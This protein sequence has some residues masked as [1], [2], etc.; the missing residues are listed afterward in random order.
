MIR[1][2]GFHPLN[3]TLVDNLNKANNLMTHLCHNDFAGALREKTVDTVG[4]RLLL[5]RI[6]GSTQE[7]DLRKPPNCDGYGRIHHFR[8][9]LDPRWTEIA[10]PMDPA[11]KALGIPRQEL[12]NAEVFQYAACNLSCWYCFVPQELTR[13]EEQHGRWF[14]AREL[15]RLYQ[16]QPEPPQIIDLS[17]GNPELVPEWVP[18]MMKALKDAH[19]ERKVYLWS[20]DSL[21]NTVAGKWLS[22]SDSELM[23]SYHAYGRV[24]CF[25]GFS[26]ESFHFNT[27]MAAEQFDQQFRAMAS[28]LSVGIDVY[29]YVTLTT[30]SVDHLRADIRSFVERLQALRLNLPLRTIPLEIVSFSPT[31]ARITDVRLKAITCYQYDAV[32][33]WREE[34]KSR[35]SS[36]QL[37]TN[38]ADVPL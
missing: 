27:G 20:D 33:C 28:L 13:G 1:V 34:L 29:A 22:P 35:F 11:C 10:I 8:R 31:K 32:D 14:S 5:A 19:L 30:P 2:S 6:A 23:R 26:P 3:A 4:E 9:H 12:M 17:G 38:V 25:K 24:G 16:A 37:A 36:E 21:T 18:W 7:Q 15:V